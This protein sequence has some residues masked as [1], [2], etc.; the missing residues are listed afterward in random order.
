MNRVLNLN[1]AYH[2]RNSGKILMPKYYPR[3]FGKSFSTT[4]A[5]FY[6]VKK[7]NDQSVPKNDLD[8]KDVNISNKNSEVN[9]SD[10]LNKDSLTENVFLNTNKL[11]KGKAILSAL[12]EEHVDHLSSAI[13]LIDND[14]SQPEKQTLIG[15]INEQIKYYE[16]KLNTRIIQHYPKFVFGSIGALWT[17]AS[18][19]GLVSNNPSAF[20]ICIGASIS[21]YLL[22]SSFSATKIEY[23]NELLKAIVRDLKRIEKK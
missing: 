12:S 21:T 8:S 16:T 11:T 10:K 5:S 6:D 1:R 14:L 7:Q 19:H 2:G 4:N 18:D 15:L 23:N 9:T 17:I 22:M 20:D 3:V 13:R